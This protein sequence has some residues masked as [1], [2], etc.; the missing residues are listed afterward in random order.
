MY[1]KH[2]TIC[3]AVIP[4][5]FNH[6]MSRLVWFS[7]MPSLISSLPFVSGLSPSALHIYYTPFGVV[8]Q[9]VF[10]KKFEKF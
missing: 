8:C 1:S 9:G 5:D 2:S 7:V 10:E 6:S 3:S 4:F